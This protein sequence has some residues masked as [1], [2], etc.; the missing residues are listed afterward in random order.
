MTLADVIID[1]WLVLISLISCS[2]GANMERKNA[3]NCG[4]IFRKKDVIAPTLYLSNGDVNDWI[5]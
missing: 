3:R 5:V 2:Y 1:V 4:L